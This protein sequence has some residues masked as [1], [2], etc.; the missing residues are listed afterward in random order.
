MGSRDRSFPGSSWASC[1]GLG[2][3]KTTGWKARTS[4]S[5]FPL[6]STCLL[7]HT[8]D[9]LVYQHTPDDSEKQFLRAAVRGVATLGC[10]R[11]FSSFWRLPAVSCLELHCHIFYFLCQSPAFLLK[12]YLCLYLRPTPTILG[13]PPHLKI[14]SIITSTKNFAT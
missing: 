7:W 6:T 12:G 10:L 2:S 8:L 4:T 13:D 11:T 1:S 9:H 3:S 14:F 5:G